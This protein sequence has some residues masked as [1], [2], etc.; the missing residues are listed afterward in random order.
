VRPIDGKRNDPAIPAGEQIRSGHRF[1][2]GHQVKLVHFRC[3]LLA[4]IFAEHKIEIPPNSGLQVDKPPA[5]RA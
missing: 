3:W 4:D 2:R 5:A 1:R